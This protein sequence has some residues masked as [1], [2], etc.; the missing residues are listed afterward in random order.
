MHYLVLTLLSCFLFATSSYAASLDDYA[1]YAYNSAYHV[2]KVRYYDEY[3][4]PVPPPPVYY[5]KYGR[6][7][8]PPPPPVYYD[9]YGRPIPP[10]PPPSRPYVD[11]RPAPPPARP[12]VDTR[13]APPP[14][15]PHVDVRPAPPPPPKR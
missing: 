3:G 11:R 2:E 14:A 7:I 15:R 8:P 5:D 4:R 1:Q 6:P 9:K 10:P 12:Y 13:P